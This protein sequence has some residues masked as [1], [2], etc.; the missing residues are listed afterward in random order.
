VTKRSG[1]ISRFVY[2][3]EA[4][5]GG[6]I[7]IGVAND[8]DRRMRS[9]QS[10]TTKTLRLIVAIPGDQADERGLHRRFNHE[11][12]NGE[13]FKSRGDVRSFVDTLLAMPE[14]DRIASIKHAAVPNPKTK[15][16][17]MR[18]RRR[19]WLKYGPNQLH[20]LFHVNDGSTGIY[21]SQEAEELMAAYR[22]ERHRF[23]LR[24]DDRH[25]P[26]GI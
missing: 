19:P 23:G 10:A 25:V 2:F 18:E 24:D 26:H 6:D 12:L 15:R 20:A 3:I 7:K 22:R 8:V 21:L 9:L 13:W 16:Q 1:E 11:R 14:V 4:G 5:K 17:N